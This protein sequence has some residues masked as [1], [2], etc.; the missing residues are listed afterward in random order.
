MSKI[1]AEILGWEEEAVYRYSDRYLKIQHGLLLSSLSGGDSDW[2][3]DKTTIAND[4]IYL[5][6]AV[7]VKPKPRKYYLKHKFLGREGFNYLNYDS[8]MER[9]YLSNKNHEPDYQTEFTDKKI[10]EIKAIGFALCNF[11]KVEVENE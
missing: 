5:K 7:K 10:K 9:F 3:F 2:Y 11:E 6:E 8:P 4:I 1:L